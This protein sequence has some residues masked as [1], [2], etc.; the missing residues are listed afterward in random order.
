MAVSTAGRP[1]FGWM[2]TGMPRPLS[3]TVTVASLWMVMSMRLA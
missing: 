1:V 2:S 3:L